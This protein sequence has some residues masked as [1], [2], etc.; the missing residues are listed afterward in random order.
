MNKKGLIAGALT[1]FYAYALFGLAFIFFL[2][3]FFFISQKPV[4]QNLHSEMRSIDA[5]TSLVSFLRA[6]TTQNK[7]M[8]ELIIQSQQLGVTER[9]ILLT[10]EA[11]KI[12][13]PE[14]TQ[15]GDL[16]SVIVDYGNN[17]E[18]T[19]ASGFGQGIPGTAQMQMISADGKAIKIE[20]HLWKN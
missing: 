16:F 19:I 6:E 4:D 5:S 12:L 7:T 14:N 2:V 17:E 11:Q 8:A 18:L 13:N 10:K 3:L 20:M 15:E 9:N 1:D